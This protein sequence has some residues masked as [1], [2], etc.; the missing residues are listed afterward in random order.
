MDRFIVDNTT[1]TGRQNIHL[2]SNMDRFIEDRLRADIDARYNL[3]SNMDRF[4][5]T[6]AH[7][8]VREWII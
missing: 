6:I 5:E 4:I 3:K 2:K 1:N 8:A 7:I